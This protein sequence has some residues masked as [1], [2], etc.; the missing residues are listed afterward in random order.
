[1][2]EKFAF[3]NIERNEV[4]KQLSQLIFAKI[5]KTDSTFPTSRIFNFNTLLIKF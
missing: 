2:M 5:F 1:M 3:I 4:V